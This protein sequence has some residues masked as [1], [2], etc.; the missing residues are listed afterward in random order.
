MHQLVFLQ[1][2]CCTEF[3]VGTGQ[4][5]KEG[6]VNVCTSPRALQ[7]HPYPG[8]GIKNEFSVGVGKMNIGKVKNEAGSFIS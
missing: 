1:D 4:K 3:N 2:H 8:M 5:K 6:V 7:L